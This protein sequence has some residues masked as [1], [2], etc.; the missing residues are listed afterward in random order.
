MIRAGNQFKKLHTD[1][2]RAFP[3]S[4][5]IKSRPAASK[6][7]GR[8]ETPFGIKAPK[9]LSKRAIVARTGS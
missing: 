5:T 4:Q 9:E 8:G 2:F 6:N 3:G 1:W 7:N